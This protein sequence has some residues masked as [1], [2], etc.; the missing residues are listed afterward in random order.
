[1]KKVILIVALMLV[2]SGAFAQS[3]QS[4]GGGQ[5]GTNGNA[6]TAPDNPA[7]QNGMREA[8]PPASIAAPATVRIARRR[9]IS[10]RRQDPLRRQLLRPEEGSPDG[11]RITPG[12][13][14]AFSLVP[15]PLI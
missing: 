14:P 9:R 4:Q 7:M 3:S 5:A 8:A 2:S 11:T 6:A 12:I 1:M 13:S 10:P 15:R